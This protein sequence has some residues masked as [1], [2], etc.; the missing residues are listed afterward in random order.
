M[1]A[2]RLA[3]FVGGKS[4]R[5]GSPKGLL[6]V[7]GGDRLILDHLAQC[8]SDAGLDPFLIGDATPYQ[9]H[10]QACPRVDDDPMG[11]GPLG[12]LRGA[13]VFAR[14][15]GARQ[16]LAVACDM[17]YVTREALARLARHESRAPVVAARRGPDAPWESMFA[18]Y[19]A[20]DVLPVLDEALA[21]GQRSFQRLLSRLE[22]DALPMDNAVFRA[23]D[24]W[25][26]PDDVVP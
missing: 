11:A 22:V 16:M 9:N 15:Q 25:D 26:T 13:L 14:S 24:D 4:T 7:P 1:T 8:G 23:L 21:A 20:T 12:G 3:I 18:R 19:D 17:P 5:M 6:P 2:V 10:A